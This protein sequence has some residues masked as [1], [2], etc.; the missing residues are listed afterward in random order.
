M[1]F[2]TLIKKTYIKPYSWFSVSMGIRGVG[3]KEA[4][5]KQKVTEFSEKQKSQSVDES[6]VEQ[7]SLS[8]THYTFESR[9]DMS[10]LYEQKWLSNGTTYTSG[11]DS[12]NTRRRI[13]N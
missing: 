5:L 3:Y 11:I 12:R 9:A 13:F 2:I 4:L 10:N 1:I 8:Y 6:F 7:P